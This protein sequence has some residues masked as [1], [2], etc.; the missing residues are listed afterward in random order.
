MFLCNQL[1]EPESKRLFR[2][3][4]SALYF[5]HSKGIA[6]RDLKLE[7]LLFDKDQ[8]LKVADF[9]LCNTMQ[10]GASL[11]TS[12]GSPDYAAPEILEHV[13]YDG[14]KVDAWS[15]GVILYTMLYGQLPFDGAN[16]SLMFQKVIDG[17][18]SF[19][20]EVAQVSAS[21]K[22]LIRKLLDPNPISRFSMK[23]AQDH[24]WLSELVDSNSYIANLNNLLVTHQINLKPKRVEDLDQKLMSKLAEIAY[25]FPL[26]NID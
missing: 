17:E 23:Q 9:G 11:N 3:L 6:H 16:Q 8:N 15:S 25:R 1:S 26:R 5:S 22:D 18:F 4:A 24:P 21:A 12:C 19:N 2:Q 13:A 20:D 7:N 10:D 14:A